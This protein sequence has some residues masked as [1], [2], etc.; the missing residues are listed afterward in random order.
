[1]DQPYLVHNHFVIFNVTVSD[2]EVDDDDDD[3][4]KNEGDIDNS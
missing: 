1:M 4:P 2:A 3:V